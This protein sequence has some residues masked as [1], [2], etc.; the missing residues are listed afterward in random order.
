[1][2]K[3]AIVPAY[4]EEASLPG[5]LRALRAEAADFDVVV[6]NDGSTDG[7]SAAARAFAGVRVVDL[8]ENIGIGGAV[9]TGFLFARA[10]GYDLAVQVDGDGQHRPSEIAKIAAPVL[11]GAADAAIGS[12]FILTRGIRPRASTADADPQSKPGAPAAETGFRGSPFRRAGIRIFQ[13]LNFL[14][15]GERITDS[16]SGFRAFNRRAIEVLSVT[17]PDDYPEPEAIY[18]LKRK[19]LRIVEV[20][21]EMAGR[22][23]GRSSIGFWHSLYYMVKVCLAIFVLLLRRDDRAG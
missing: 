16:T 22:A 14:L 9:Q 15:L 19:G 5:V 18:I 17:Y 8:P 21:V 20:P 4:N 6:I 23:A 2:K 7:T 12:R 11:S 3:I 13:A 10:G 1:M